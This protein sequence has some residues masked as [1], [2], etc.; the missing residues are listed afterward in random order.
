MEKFD[1][2]PADRAEFC[3]LTDGVKISDFHWILIDRD[4]QI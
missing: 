3:I 1:L 4:R 2:N